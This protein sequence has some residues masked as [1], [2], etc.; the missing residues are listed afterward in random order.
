MIHWRNRRTDWDGKQF[1]ERGA[2]D[3][4][5]RDLICQTSKFI[6]EFWGVPLYDLTKY[7]VGKVIT[8]R[9]D[10]LAKFLKIVINEVFGDGN[11]RVEFSDGNR[12]LRMSIKHNGEYVISDELSDRLEKIASSASF[13]FLM[14]EDE[15]TILFPA[16]YKPFVEFRTG[17][18]A[19]IYRTLVYVFSQSAEEGQ[20]TEDITE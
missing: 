8:F 6:K 14:K 12:S 16:R 15:I 13:T 3:F 5:A 17:E 11:W 4:N 2:L 1:A 19:I 7:S 20:G 10:T 18:A 9:P